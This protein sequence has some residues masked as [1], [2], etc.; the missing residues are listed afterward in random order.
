M[1]SDIPL[2]GMGTWRSPWDVPDGE[3]WVHCAAGYRSSIAASILAAGGRRDAVDDGF[4]GSLGEPGNAS[5]AWRIREHRPRRAVPV[6][7]A[8]R[9]PQW[10][11]DQS[12]LDQ[13]RPDQYRPDQ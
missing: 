10:A 6:W 13:Y 8:W 11:V 5:S 9:Q 4:R 7:F 3:V 1:L 2:G 12:S